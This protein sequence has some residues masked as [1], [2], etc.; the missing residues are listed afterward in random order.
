MEFKKEVK[1]TSVEEAMKELNHELDYRKTPAIKNFNNGTLWQSCYDDLH[2]KAQKLVDAIENT[3]VIKTCPNCKWNYF[4][5]L[6]D[7]TKFC[8]PDCEAE[9]EGVKVPCVGANCGGCNCEKEKHKSLWKDVMKFKLNDLKHYL[10]KRKSG[11]IIIFSNDHSGLEYLAKFD[12]DKLEFSEFCSMNDIIEAFENLQA[13]HEQLQR[14]V[15]EI[16]RKIK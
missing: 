6:T 16:K 2:I 9:S 12:E 15:E 11:E 3:D 10:L 5:L 14:D 8:S 7:P 1:V 4:S 13:S